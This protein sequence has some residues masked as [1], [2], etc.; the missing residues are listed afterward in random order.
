MTK[1]EARKRLGLSENDTISEDGVKSL[2]ESTEK[3]LTVWS[4]G[5]R[6]RENLEKDLEAYRALLK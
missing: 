3:L 2:I 1:Q 4:I 5:K 6:D